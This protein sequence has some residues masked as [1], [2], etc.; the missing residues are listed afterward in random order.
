MNQSRTMSLVEAIANVV[1]GYGIAVVAQIM[2]F[3]LFE[4]HTTLAENLQMGAVFTVVS[5]ARSFG[6]RRLF[7]VIRVRSS[8]FTRERDR[9]IIGSRSSRRQHEG[10]K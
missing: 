5:I 7:E 3:P 10:A 4:L 8:G 6:L 9:V 1:V 2:I